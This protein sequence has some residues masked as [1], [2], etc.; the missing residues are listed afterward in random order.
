MW[1]SYDGKTNIT[2]NQVIDAATRYQN[3]TGLTITIDGTEVDGGADAMGETA[4]GETFTGS[5]EIDANGNATV[6]FD[7]N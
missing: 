3:M 4:A 2:R 5:V 6:D 1:S 7:T